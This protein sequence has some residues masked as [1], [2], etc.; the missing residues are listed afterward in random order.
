MPT[1]NCQ[2][3]ST[4]RQ[5][6]SGECQVPSA[7]CQVPS[8]NCQLPAAS[9]QL[10][11]DMFSVRG[12]THETGHLKI[13]VHVSSHLVFDGFGFAEETE[14]RIRLAKN[15]SINEAMYDRILLPLSLQRSLFLK[16]LQVSIETAQVSRVR[17]PRHESPGSSHAVEYYLTRMLRSWQQDWDSIIL[18][19]KHRV[20]R[21]RR[22][23]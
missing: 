14:T 22:L 19:F 5:I 20:A 3:P 11:T 1:A 10:P 6:T 9:C 8:A 21:S 18:N 16:H 12:Q 17:N 23:D 7:K 2:L 15:S 13:G 4:Q